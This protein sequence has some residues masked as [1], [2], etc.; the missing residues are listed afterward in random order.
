M[1]GAATWEVRWR[2]VRPRLSSRRGSSG[3]TRT[4]ARAGTEAGPGT[5]PLRDAAGSLGVH[6]VRSSMRS[7]QRRHAGFVLRGPRKNAVDM[8]PETGR[9]EAVVSAIAEMTRWCVAP[10]GT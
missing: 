1:G 10:A 9:T 7:G 2:R 4:A 8:L 5:K 3:T 6:S